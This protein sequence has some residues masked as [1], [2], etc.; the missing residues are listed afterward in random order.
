MGT[1]WYQ[2][3]KPFT[4]V[5]V[6]C[7]GSHK[8]LALWVNHANVGFLTLRD[9][10]VRDV[11]RKLMQMDPTAKVRTGRPEEGLLVE[12]YQ[13]VD[14]ETTLINEYG[15]VTTATALRQRASEGGY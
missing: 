7:H 2:L 1:E 4:H 14:G 8:H 3:S 11:L 5:R 6:G 12:W 10:E 13:E 9:E 15:D